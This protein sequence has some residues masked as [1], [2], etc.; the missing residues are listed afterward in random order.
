MNPSERLEAIQDLEYSEAADQGRASA[1]VVSGQMPENCMGEHNDDLNQIAI[2]GNLL[3]SDTPDEC[4]RTYFHEER[5]AYQHSQADIMASADDPAKAA[6][7][8][9]NFKDGNYI[10]PEENFA[11]YARQP[12]EVDANEYS[13]QRFAEYEAQAQAQERAAPAE[14]QSQNQ[15]QEQEQNQA[16]G[17]DQ[18]QDQGQEQDQSHGQGQETGVGAA[19]GNGEWHGA[20]WAMKNASAR[21]GRVYEAES[22]A[23]AYQPSDVS[24]VDYESGNQQ[25]YNAIPVYAVNDSALSVGNGGV[26]SGSAGSGATSGGSGEDERSGMSY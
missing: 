13:E 23:P 20:G 15:D 19:E 8:A 18:N 4:L 3:R 21:P 22:D 24:G 1:I 10:T 14:S 25:I 5:H 2:D 7:W 9:E 26:G 11:A 6:Q 17:Q 16:Q 12:V